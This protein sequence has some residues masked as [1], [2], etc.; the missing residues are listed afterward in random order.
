MALAVNAMIGIDA[1]RASARRSRVAPS[2]SS[3]GICMSMKMTS[4][5]AGDACAIATAS[6]PFSPTS[7]W[8]PSRAPSSV[9]TIWL[10]SLSSARSAVLP[11][12]AISSGTSAPDR[13]AWKRPPCDSTT[14]SKSDDAVTG[15]RRKTLT[16][17]AAER[18]SSSLPA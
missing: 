11:T 16:P 15:L 1:K 6:R 14:A 13:G 2:P 17:M 12:N 3:S 9:T 18:A 5:L 10:A 7:I 4:Y 8:R